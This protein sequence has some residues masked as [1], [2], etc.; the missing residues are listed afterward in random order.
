MSREPPPRGD[1]RSPG[2]AAVHAVRRG[3]RARRTARS[4]RRPRVVTAPAWRRHFQSDQSPSGVRPVA[5][6][7]PH[8]DPRAQRAGRRPAPV[9][10]RWP[11]GRSRSRARCSDPEPRSPQREGRPVPA[12]SSPTRSRRWCRC[13]SP[14]GSIIA[15][16]RACDLNLV[17]T[18]LGRRSR[19]RRAIRRAP[20][21]RRV[22]EPAPSPR[23]RGA[24]I[25]RSSSPSSRCERPARPSRTSD[26]AGSSVR[27]VTRA[28][29]VG[30]RHHPQVADMR[31]LGGRRRAW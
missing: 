26:V 13:G 9:V 2:P 22:R 7:H 15:M 14:R 28:V 24:W 5:G 23:R 31:V 25:S 1:A 16:P 8:D 17:G 6:T 3:E 27:Q 18:P 29:A 11:C 10:A 30:Q 21:R 4:D 19:R 12:S 20:V